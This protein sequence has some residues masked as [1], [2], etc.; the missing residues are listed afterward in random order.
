MKILL[1]G[2]PL[3]IAGC[4]HLT[5]V[6]SDALFF[7]QTRDTFRRVHDS[8]IKV[9]EVFAAQIAI[10]SLDFFV[11]LSSFCGLV[12]IPGQTNYAR[13]VS[14]LVGSNIPNHFQCLYRPGRC[15]RSVS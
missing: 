2:L 13:F 11:A 7:N 1:R 15:S 12:G 9:F 10:E 14:V 5:L 8:K 3:P 4:F 6:L